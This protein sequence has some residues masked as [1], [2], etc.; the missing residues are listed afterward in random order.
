MAQ[1]PDIRLVPEFRVSINGSELSE[2]AVVDIIDVTVHTEINAASMF[3]I[4]MINWDRSAVQVTWVDDEQFSPG[5]EVKIEGGYVDW[6][7]ELI[8]GEI[9]GL[10]AEFNANDIPSLIVRGYDHRHRLLRGRNTR[11]FIDMK[12]SDIASQIASETGLAAETEDTGTVLKYVAQSNQTD[13]EFLQDRAHR[14]GYEVTI[15][16]KTLYFRPRQNTSGEVLILTREEDL[17][18]FYPCLSTMGLPGKVIVRAY[19]PGEKKEII[20]EAGI[21]DEFT[22][23]GGA[24]SGP[25]AAQ[26][27]FDE[28]TSS[29]VDCPVF[30]QAEADQMALGRFNDMALTYIKG[31]GVCIGR[32]DLQ[33]GT[34]IKIEDIGE[35]LSGLYY[36]TSVTHI[37]SANRGYSTAFT[38]RRNAEGAM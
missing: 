14:I 4:E 15:K 32:P 34:V 17:L 16:D 11:S 10:D 38:V 21:G 3:T 19:N 24:T 2:E 35:R 27:A 13:L 1:P 25:Q 8:V 12:D 37:F 23:M 7:E 20:G 18:E 33:A 36:V 26:D 9:I 30:S 22:T 5:N 28:A 6:S 29:I 31:E